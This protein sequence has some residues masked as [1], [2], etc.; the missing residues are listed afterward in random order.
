MFPRNMS[1][2]QGRSGCCL[3][4]H[5]QAGRIKVGRGSLWEGPQQGVKNP[6]P[7]SQPGSQSWEYGLDRKWLR[8]ERKFLP[9]VGQAKVRAGTGLE[10]RLMASMPEQSM[11]VLFP[12]IQWA[13]AHSKPH[14][15]S[16]YLLPST[17]DPETFSVS[18]S[19]ASRTHAFPEFQ[20]LVTESL[21]LGG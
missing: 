5:R 12:S 13:G 15:H 8:H 9:K 7:L 18:L 10:A 11:R 17:T 6:R 3:Q 21:Q 2:N 14:L 19:Y 20:D 1:P 16:H 4:I